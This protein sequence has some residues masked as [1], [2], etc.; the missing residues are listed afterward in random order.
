[1]DEQIDALLI[2]VQGMKPSYD[3]VHARK[4]RAEAKAA[5]KELLAEAKLEQ[6]YIINGKLALYTW[7][8]YNP[9]AII[10]EAI[11]E[12]QAINTNKTEEVK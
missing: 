11:E 7:G 2:E 9:Y 10:D 4:L 3:S 5:I 8:H 1:M 6:T 12:L